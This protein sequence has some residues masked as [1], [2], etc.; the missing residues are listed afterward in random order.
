MVCYNLLQIGIKKIITINVTAYFIMII[1]V[2][3]MLQLTT[4]W[5]QKNN[6]DKCN[7]IFYYDYTCI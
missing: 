2:Y 5:Y 4:D 1:H 3:D 6:N 7:S